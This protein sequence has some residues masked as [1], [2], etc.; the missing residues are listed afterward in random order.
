MKKKL[1]KK[2]VKNLTIKQLHLNEKESI[3]QCQEKPVESVREN[4]YFRG[5][6]GQFTSSKK[7]CFENGEEIQNSII[8]HEQLNINHH[9]GQSDKMV[10]ISILV[11]IISNIIY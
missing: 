3:T 1:K 7:R 11:Y 6:N 10:S 5:N 9:P 4:S 8:K 2:V